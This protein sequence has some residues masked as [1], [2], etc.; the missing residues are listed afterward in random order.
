MPNI[1][2]IEKSVKKN[3]QHCMRIIW[4]FWEHIHEL[5]VN[6]IDKQ[7]VNKQLHAIGDELTFAQACYRIVNDG[8]NSTTE[9]DEVNTLYFKT[10]ACRNLGECSK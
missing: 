9:N 10:K 2:F 7:T 6:D 4:E 3:G 5:F 8:V 1:D